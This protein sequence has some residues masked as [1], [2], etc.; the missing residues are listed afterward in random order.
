L[1]DSDSEPDPLASLA[2]EFVE[3]Y[4]RGERPSLSEYIARYPDEA[5]R[6]KHLFPALVEM[7][8][9]G[10]VGGQAGGNLAGASPGRGRVPVQ[11][12]EYRIVRE[13][14]RGGMGVVYEAVQESLGR[15]V[16]LKV[17]PAAGLMSPTHLE[18]FRREA[19]AA[20]RLHHTNIVPVFGVGEHEGVHYFAM[21]F[22]RGQSLDRVMHELA[23]LR[24]LNDPPPFAG[25]LPRA[26]LSIGIAHGLLSDRF[27][28]VERPR[29][30]GDAPPPTEDW[31]GATDGTPEGT[32]S[33][34]LGDPSG[35]VDQ[36]T[37][38]YSRSVA[39]VGVQVADALAYSHGQGILHRD[40]KPANL[41]L[42]T[43]GTVWVSDFGL[44]K[45]HGTEELTTQ[46]DFVGTLRYM[47]PERFSGRSDPRSDVYGLGLT[48][49]EML[50]L[51]PAFL[52]SDRGR[53]VERVQ[54]EEPT[55]PR[56]VD[57]HIP[58]DL[59]TVVLKAMAK[60]PGRR[61]ATA[62]AMADDLRRFLADRPVKARRA[63]AWEVVWRWARRNPG[64]AASTAA[65]AGLLVVVAG[66]WMVWTARLGSELRRTTSAQQAEGDAKKDAL[67][68][69]WRSHL[70]RARAGRFS[71]RPGQR[72]D[73]LAAIK[74]AVGIARQVGAAVEEM[75][76]L[77]NEAIAC[78]ALPDLR[79]GT[80]SVA[81][82]P[83]S[84]IA[85]DGD[86]GRYALTDAQGGISIFNLGDDRLIASVPGLGR[87]YQLVRL[88]ADG[89]L[90]VGM[91]DRELQAWAVEG[92][93]PV[94]SKPVAAHAPIQFR[95]D[96]NLLAVKLDG[97]I[98]M[99]DLRTGQE[100]R[101]LRTEVAPHTIALNPDGRR[102]AV[103]YGE[104]ASDLEIWDT[105]S[106]KKLI[107][108]PVGKDG[109][110]Y[111]VAWHPDGRQLGLGFE[112][113]T[114]K[115]QIWDA[116]LG[117]PLVTVESH[118][119]WV[120]ELA[121]HPN[122]DL[123]V[124]LSGDGTSR[125]WDAKTGR[126]LVNWPSAMGEMH[127]S[128]DGTICGFTVIGGR[129][130][131]ME[132]ADGREYRT[133]VNT[134]GADRGEYREGG[135]SADG[136]LAVGTEDGALLWDLATGDEVAFFPDERTDSV[137][138]IDRPDGRELL[139]CGSGGLRRW[140]ICEGAN[141]PERLRIGPPRALDLRI[142]PTRA[143][144]RQDGRA[145]AVASEDLGI[146]LIVDLPD[147]ARRCILT[148]H[149]GLNRAVSSPDGRWVATSGWHTASIKLWDAGTG[150]M[151]KDLA[152]GG[153][154]IAFFSPDGRT[155]VTSRGDGYQCWDVPSWLPGLRLPVEIQSYPGWVAFSPDRKLLALELSPAV[156]HL[157]V[158]ATGRTVAKLE[159]P[160]SDRAQWLSFT[161]DGAGLVS[162]ARY[163]K[164]IHVWDLRA[165]RRHLALM[166]VDWE[167]P[168]YAA[169]PIAE[170][171]R[172]LS[173]E[174]LFG[175]PSDVLRAAADLARSKIL[176]YRRI[177][178]SNPNNAKAHY[179]LAWA[180]VTA[181]EGLRDPALALA[182]ALRA[183]ELK[184][185]VPVI[186]STL[187]VAYYRAG[188]YREAAATLKENLPGQDEQGLASDLYFLA[189][190][191]HQLG[192]VAAARAYYTWAKRATASQDERPGA[193]VKERDAFRAEA[194]KLLG[195]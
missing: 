70:A 148:P 171:R 105:D 157:V 58:R 147:G 69:L 114:G 31:S 25:A 151:V 123:L 15:H 187:G 12:G 112:G 180:Y 182:M 193:D 51:R 16:A 67:D 37:L 2:E 7:E 39:R 14:A 49:Y 144:V 190:S 17:L 32:S 93:K 195:E 163:S 111:A 128:R 134:L 45:E 101:C 79:P 8:Q 116:A 56:K 59:E 3:R 38:A 183:S 35:L 65:A 127:F 117:R 177:V 170:P 76:E 60:D 124:S 53:L 164:S 185:R 137:S 106:G 75:D 44:V 26:E 62:T 132:V 188:R 18:R 96:S 9:L 189:M 42:D 33:I 160:R 30:P 11:L 52:D 29:P 140:P 167:S 159:D 121:F 174:S 173:V 126:L 99:W 57:A 5:E 4:R 172:P 175:D 61:Y 149:S 40:I 133:L 153:N 43:R 103:A 162:I 73:S 10:S 120:G 100:T 181:P 125:L 13:V 150:S 78:L 34:V 186:R 102:L 74:E 155:L 146:G 191:Y 169:A 94:F 135:I 118:T 72:L 85:F 166:Q 91:D 82:Q 83:G 77:R 19:R 54:H 20:A 55:R 192:D 21:Q 24:R 23:R 88:S 136:L 109:S 119:Q 95:G 104:R 145:I 6:I 130:R 165:I 131:L 68:K 176:T 179:A 98:G 50:T 158:V 41:L 84:A 143:D 115:I 156:I 46:G 178:D 1:F 107:E 141:A 87:A 184:P 161:P 113:S 81:L 122:G 154:N 138:F 28:D 22:I 36:S 80:T 142:A 92:G 108:S 194:E 89:R 47:A 48:L 97:S 110:L 86:Y 139:T 64:L 63:A 71:R 129:A 27:T 152:V 168:P 90:V 66:L